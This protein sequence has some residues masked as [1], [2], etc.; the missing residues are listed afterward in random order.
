M[1]ERWTHHID[2]LTRDFKQE[3][4]MLSTEELNWKPNANTWSIGQNIDHLIIINNTYHPIIN[5][6]RTGTYRKPLLARFDFM[7]SFLGR[8]VLGAV[9][10]DRKK[11]MKTFPIWEPAKSDIQ[12]D[13]LEKFEKQ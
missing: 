3:F 9:Q 1:Q 4:G 7:V 11:R 12:V 2:Q 8:I 10:P 13:I 6:V 5:A